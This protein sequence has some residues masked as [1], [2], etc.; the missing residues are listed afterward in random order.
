[1][2]SIELQLL[3]LILIANGT[4][5]IA[6]AVCGAW[7]AWPLDGGR[8]LADGRRLLG[9]AKTWRGVALAPLA[10]GL[11]AVL[12]GWPA[13]VGII[14]GIAAMLGDLLSSFVKRRLGVPTSGM[15]LGLD[16]IPEAL[17]P[18]LAVADR[19]A[20]S[21]PAIAATVAGFIVLELGLSP[22]FYWLGVRNRPY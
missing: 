17:L 22:I 11:G 1:M 20:L 14:I 2:A 13:M 9:E 5:V 3:L 10:A 7:C 15:A 8:V 4:P 19:F 18:L 12:L 6:A 16:Q 21:W